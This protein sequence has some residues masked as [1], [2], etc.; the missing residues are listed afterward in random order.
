MHAAVMTINKEHKSDHSENAQALL[1]AAGL[2]GA[3][4]ASSCCILP[5]ALFG[6]GVSGAWISHLTQLAPYQPLFLATAFVCLSAGTWLVG[7][8]STKI[9]AGGNA[10][11]R[12][13]PRR[14]TIAAL[15]IAALVVAAA[16][17]F[18]ILGPLVLS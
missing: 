1:A 11:V 6:L 4:A 8:T 9:C 5:V 16:I 12:R 7:R 10:C 17:G 13:L 18:D 2:L 15:I 3:L 14:L